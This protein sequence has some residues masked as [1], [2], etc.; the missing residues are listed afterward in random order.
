MSMELRTGA[1]EGVLAERPRAVSSNQ[2]KDRPG[3]F[4]TYFVIGLAIIVVGTAVAS[5]MPLP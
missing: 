3:R 5:F 4:A 1:N 2:V